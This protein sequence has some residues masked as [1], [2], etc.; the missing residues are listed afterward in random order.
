MSYTDIYCFHLVIITLA[1]TL[2]K[3]FDMKKHSES[4]KKIGQKFIKKEM[5]NPQIQLQSQKLP[6][7]LLTRKRVLKPVKNR[8]KRPK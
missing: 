2:I 8:Q 6:W 1:L 3:Q 7:T 4:Q 5:K